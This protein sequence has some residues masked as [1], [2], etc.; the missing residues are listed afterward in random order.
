MNIYH[1]SNSKIWDWKLLFILG[2][3]RCD[4]D[5]GFCNFAVSNNCNDNSKAGFKWERKTSDNIKNN[6]LEGPDKGTK[7]YWIMDNT[8]TRNKTIV[9]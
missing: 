2:T 7:Q 1:I 3:I 6:G 5:D 4:F 8:S 9:L